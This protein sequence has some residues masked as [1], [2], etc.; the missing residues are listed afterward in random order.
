[1][2]AAAEALAGLLRASG[3]VLVDWCRAVT[4]GAGDVRAYLDAVLGADGD[5][6][7]GLRIGT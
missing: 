4:V 7:G 1:V 2:A 3:L 5:V 6:S